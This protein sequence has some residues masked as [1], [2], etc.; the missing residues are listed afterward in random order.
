MFSGESSNP[1]PPPAEGPPHPENHSYCKDNSRLPPRKGG[2]LRVGTLAAWL[3]ASGCALRGDSTVSRDAYATAGDTTR[4][5][6]RGRRCH[7][8]E[9]RKRPRS[10]RQRPRRCMS[11]SCRMCTHVRLRRRPRAHGEGRDGGNQ[12]RHTAPAASYSRGSSS[13]FRAPAAR[14]LFWPPAAGTSGRR[15]SPSAD[16]CVFCSGWST[17][18][19]VIRAPNFFYCINR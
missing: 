9:Y 10:R 6:F 17:R 5:D 11:A 14:S 7:G 3:A 19:R 16:F 12:M 1:P 2:G 15:C 8:W 4:G 18:P 13:N